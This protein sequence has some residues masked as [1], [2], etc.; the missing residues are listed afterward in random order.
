[1]CCNVMLC[2]SFPAGRRTGR[3]TTITKRTL[4]VAEQVE[5]EELSMDHHSHRSPHSSPGVGH[6]GSANTGTETGAGGSPGHGIASDDVEGVVRGS[7]A[8]MRRTRRCV[9]EEEIVEQ[10]CMSAEVSRAW[11]IVRSD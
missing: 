2:A 1:M 5:E 9:V 8:S 7:A 4:R 6:P 11:H 10:V 3:V